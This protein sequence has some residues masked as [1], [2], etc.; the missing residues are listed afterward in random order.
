MTYEEAQQELHRI[1][2]QQDA[3]S[4]KRLNIGYEHGVHSALYSQIVQ[5]YEHV[6]ESKRIVQRALSAPHQRYE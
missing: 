3:L 1:E 5:E 4:I 6:L 2:K